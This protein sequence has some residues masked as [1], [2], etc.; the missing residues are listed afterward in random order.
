MSLESCRWPI[1]RS[2]TTARLRSSTPRWTRYLSRSAT[3]MAHTNIEIKAR[4]TNQDQIRA[5]FLKNGADFKGTDHQI[6]TYF[7]VE[8]GRLKLREG[9]IENFLVF[10][11]R[12]DKEEPKQS[13]VILL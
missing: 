11:E 9:N 2:P 3:D 7:K 5:F 8:N 4:S 13:N 12:E 10:Y 1:T 6:D